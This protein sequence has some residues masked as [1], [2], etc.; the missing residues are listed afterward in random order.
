MPITRSALKKLRQDKKR[1]KY[2]LLVKKQVR[3]I[4]RDFKHS[5]TPALLNKLVGLLDTA[6]KKNIFHPNKAARLKSKFSKLLNT[7]KQTSASP[8]LSPPKK[9]I[10][11]KK[12]SVV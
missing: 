12:K 6:A 4:M 2:N 8:A 5:P 9:K 7:K 1:T 3:Q 11:R 10:P